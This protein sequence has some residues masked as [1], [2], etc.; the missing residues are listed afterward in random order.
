MGEIAQQRHCWGI[1]G[2]SAT[3]WCYIHSMKYYLSSSSDIALWVST[4][5]VKKKK[6]RINPVRTLIETL[7]GF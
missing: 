4:R 3:Q 7:N 1:W 6:E 2:D 5:K